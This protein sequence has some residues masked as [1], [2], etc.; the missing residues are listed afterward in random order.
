MAYANLA[1][2]CRQYGYREISQLLADESDQLTEDML[3]EAVAGDDLSLYTNSEQVAIEAAVERAEDALE[4]QSAYMDSLI[5]VRY[6]LP[7]PV[8][9]VQISPLRECCLAL[10]RAYLADDADN[11]SETIDASRQRWVKWL[12]DLARDNAIIQNAPRVS[13]GA[14][15][16]GYLTTPIP[17][18]TDLS[19]Y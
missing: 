2:L 7:L 15:S 17:A 16:G 9:A 1:E 4:R 5:G 6:Q 14:S 10:S 8:E 11:E 19:A 18:R 13:A 12:N 3:L